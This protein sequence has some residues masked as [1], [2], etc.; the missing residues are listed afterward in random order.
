MFI[1]SIL[2]C[3]NPLL[4]C[5]IFQDFSDKQ[6]I[7]FLEENNI[8]REGYLGNR[9]SIAIREYTRQVGD[10]IYLWGKIIRGDRHQKRLNP[11]LIS[12]SPRRDLM[13]ILIFLGLLGLFFLTFG[14]T[15]IY[16]ILRY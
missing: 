14:C 5:Y 10:P 8:K 12:H 16:Q 1:A 6:A 3:L 7:A 4:A 2:F 13:L 11:W 9:K 15:I